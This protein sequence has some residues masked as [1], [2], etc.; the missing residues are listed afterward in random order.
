MDDLVRGTLG[1]V[2]PGPL[3]QQGSVCQKVGPAMMAWA[4]QKRIFPL[5][6]VVFVIHCV[7]RVFQGGAAAV[8]G[9]GVA[10]G[11]GNVELRGSSIVK[12]FRHQD[13]GS[14]TVRPRAHGEGCWKRRSWERIRGCLKVRCN[15][16]GA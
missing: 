12:E 8:L 14:L 6:L 4:P 3:V 9:V 1:V 15:K 10:L 2:L 11:E 13:V 5:F 16:V 7:G